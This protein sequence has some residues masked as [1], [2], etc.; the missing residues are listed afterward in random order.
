[1]AI[2]HYFASNCQDNSIPVLRFYGWDPYCMSIGYHQKKELIN[3]KTLTDDGY[4]LVRRPTGGRA[5]F[6]AGELTYGIISPKARTD[7]HHLYKFIH[8]IL[9]TALNDLGYPV[10]L[11]SDLEKLPRLRH[12]ADD[13]PCFTRSAQTEVQ[14]EG[15]KIIGSAQKIYKHSILQHGSILIG[16]EHEILPKYLLVDKSIKTSIDIEISKKTIHLNAIGKYNINIEKLIT[17]ILNQLDKLKNISLYF[18]QLNQDELRN[19]KKHVGAFSL[20]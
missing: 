14:F 15:K 20:Q 6:H 9:S 1:M 8:W 16:C 13:Y 17:S 7:Q 19:A 3:I 18:K 5:I 11:K 10:E 2:D 12:E 4:D